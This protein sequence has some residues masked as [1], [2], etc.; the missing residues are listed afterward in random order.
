[1]SVPPVVACPFKSTNGCPVDRDAGSADTSGDTPAESDA[2]SDRDDPEA[3]V[4]DASPPIDAE[5]DAG[6][7]DESKDDP[8]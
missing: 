4:E 8:G 5:L 2:S 6:S 1:V 3:S 7:A